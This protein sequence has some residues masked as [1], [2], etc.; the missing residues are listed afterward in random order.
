[1]A[2]SNVLWRHAARARTR[3]AVVLLLSLLH[4]LVRDDVLVVLDSR[5]QQ[6]D[7]GAA[8]P[9]DRRWQDHPR[10]LVGD[11]ERTDHAGALAAYAAGRLSDN[12]H[13]RFG[14]RSLVRAARRPSRR[15]AR[16]AALGPWTGRGADPD[17]A[18]L[19]SP[20][21]PLRAQ[22]SAREVCGD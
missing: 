7:A 17:P 20:D 16:D 15:S 10:G 4:G 8:R 1:H 12:R 22:A 14:H 6:L 21:G 5:Q 11:H 19:R 2:G 3:A 18:L 9:R 13:V